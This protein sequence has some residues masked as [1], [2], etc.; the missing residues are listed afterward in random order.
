MNL[1]LQVLAAS[2]TAASFLPLESQASPFVKQEGKIGL[3][4]V[5]SE[6]ASRD[7]VG[8]EDIVVQGHEVLTVSHTAK[9]TYGLPNNMDI[10]LGGTFKAVDG[11]RKDF[12]GLTEI[13]LDYKYLFLMTA[14]VYT[15]FSFGYHHPGKEYETSSL[16]AP[17]NNAYKIP[18]GV[19]TAYYDPSALP[20]MA[21][22]DLK[23]NVREG[24]IPDQTNIR[25][26]LYYIHQAFSVGTFYGMVNSQG[27][28]DLATPEFREKTVENGN[29]PP[30]PLVAEKY[31]YV[32]G[33]V[34]AN[35]MAY[36]VGL[37]YVEKLKEGMKNSDVNNNI[38]LSVG[39]TL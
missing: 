24:D 16:D 11:E 15:A 27:G 4:Y 2:L 12:V 20:L 6:G 5:Y 3:Q 1:K 22:L 28:Y 39:T 30:Y 18:I 8:K 31:N 19:S 9:A 32:G 25:F 21:S 10:S 37:S 33:A 26:D 23:Y 7:L 13:M 35:V 17:G 38:S 36:S 14:P 29:K 34:Y